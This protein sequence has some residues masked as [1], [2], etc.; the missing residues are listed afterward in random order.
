MWTTDQ[1]APHPLHNLLVGGVYLPP[2]AFGLSR[3]TCFGQ[4]DTDRN[5]PV[6]SFSLKQPLGFHLLSGA[7]AITVRPMRWPAQ[8]EGDRC[9]VPPSPPRVGL[10][11]GS[12]PKDGKDIWD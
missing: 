6:P 10:I 2:L 9:R 8:E 12:R 4:L 3:V 11:S 7:P 5:V 1:L